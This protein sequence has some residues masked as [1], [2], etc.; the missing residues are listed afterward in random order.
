MS[1]SAGGKADETDAV[2]PGAHRFYLC[3]VT[4]RRGVDRTSAIGWFREKR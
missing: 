4:S 1:L 3:G 2:G